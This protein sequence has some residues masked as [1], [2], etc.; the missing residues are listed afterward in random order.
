MCKNL[1]ADNR[2][3]KCPYEDVKDINSIKHAKVSAL[4]GR[5]GK[6]KTTVKYKYCRMAETIFAAL[7]FAY[8]YPCVTLF[9]SRRSAKPRLKTG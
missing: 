2:C 8:L 1:T 4:A 6:K 3:F 5:T 7:P 9:L